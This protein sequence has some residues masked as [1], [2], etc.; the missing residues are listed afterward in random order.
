MKN[1]NKNL[2]KTR[3]SVTEDFVI[4]NEDFAQFGM[5]LDSEQF[6]TR[7][8]HPFLIK[9]P[10]DSSEK[11]STGDFGTTAAAPPA[12]INQT[13]VCG[14]TIFFVK[15]SSKNVFND[16]ITIGD[17]VNNDIVLKT[18]NVSKFHAYIQHRGSDW[19]LYDSG[20]VSGTFVNRLRLE[21]KKPIVLKPPAEL[22]F[23]GDNPLQFLNSRQTS[24]YLRDLLQGK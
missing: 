14:A 23:G 16:M 10:V 7:F 24:Q 21:Q 1:D 17:T 22:N 2:S 8:P 11:S 19:W 3:F 9:A 15:K 12:T 18:P 4:S 6:E 5:I 20:S 13:S